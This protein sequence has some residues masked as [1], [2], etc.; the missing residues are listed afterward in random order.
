MFHHTYESLPP[1][2]SAEKYIFHSN[3]VQKSLLSINNMTSCFQPE[4]K[5]V[6]YLLGLVKCVPVRAW[7]WFLSHILH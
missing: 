5:E 4:V 3:K 1:D 2:E 7:I 6:F